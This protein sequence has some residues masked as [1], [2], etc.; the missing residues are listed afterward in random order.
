M[1]RP[2]SFAVLTLTLVV[3]QARAQADAGDSIP[4]FRL[5]YRYPSVGVPSVAALAPGGRLGL[6]IGAVAVAG[7]W[8]RRVRDA[9]PGV[10]LAHP[11]SIAPLAAAPP[12]GPQA[13]PAFRAAGATGVL[14]QFASLGMELSLRFELKADQF[15][16]LKCNA[17]ER[18]QALHGAAHLVD[19]ALLLKGVEI[20]AANFQ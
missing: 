7:A 18:L 9:L 13:P 3:P 1:W 2:A 17:F 11:P 4:A 16:N 15:R 6:R 20:D 5:S 14:G 8:E 10:D 12:P 19:Q